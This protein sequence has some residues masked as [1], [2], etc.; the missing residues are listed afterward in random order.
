M[1]NP[2]L[3]AELLDHTVDLLQDDT[4]ALKS[5]CLVSKSWI[6]RARRHLFADVKLNSP[7]RLEAWKNAF[8][9]PSTSPACYAKTLRIRFLVEVPVTDAQEG[10]WIPTFSRVEHLEVGTGSMTTPLV[11]F[12]GFSPKMKSLRVSTISLPFSRIFNLIFSFP[13]LEDL[14]IDALYGSGPEDD[15][16]DQLA[17]TRPSSLPPFTGSLNLFIFGGSYRIAS[18][19]LALPGGLR[20]RE[21]RL[22]LTNESVSSS[23]ALVEEC[24]STLESL[25]INCHVRGMSVPQPHSHRWL[26]S[27]CSSGFNRSIK[28]HEAQKCSI[29][30]RIRTTM[31]HYVSKN[32]H[33]QPPKFSSAFNR[34]NYHPQ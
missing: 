20:F 27:A 32:Y 19:L 7:V 11:L 4:D 8:P 23:I 3:P 1:S 24:S 15:L 10:G 9:N 13:F 34:R 6:S 31:D 22:N 16:Q 30:V 25:E 17:T 28:S 12:H 33:A 29:C 21:L 26:N 18:Q 14:S 5:C 2:D